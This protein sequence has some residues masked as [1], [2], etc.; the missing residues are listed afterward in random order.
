MI[1]PKKYEHI[2]FDLD[3]TLWD[4]ETNSAITLKIIFDDFE[5]ES[6]KIN[7]SEFKNRYSFHNFNLWEQL[8]RGFITR[9]E[10]RVN[11][12]VF[13]LKEFGIEDF[14]LCK[15]LSDKYLE[16]LPEQKKL[17]D[18]ANEVVEL[19]SKKYQLHI[20]TNGFKQVQHKK[21][22]N[23]GLKNYFKTITTS[24]EAEANKPHQKI[25]DHAF[26]LS[27]AKPDNSLMIGDN[28]FADMSGAI[29]AGMDCILFNTMQYKHD[30][31]VNLEI[32]SLR[33]LL[34]IF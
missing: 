17:F 24:E 33:D 23:C 5:L 26:M 34:K 25:F 20:I 7:F 6:K 4:F 8:E 16:V 1:N 21:L 13:T 18:G 30:V 14:E 10:V 27:K 11:R 32:N 28:P 31:K 19:L 2:F 15:H 12:F 29:N 22:N 3:H 9:A